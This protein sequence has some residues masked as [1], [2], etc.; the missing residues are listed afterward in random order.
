MPFGPVTQTPYDPGN[1][2]DRRYV[3]TSTNTSSKVVNGQPAFVV[4]K[5]V[6]VDPTT[7]ERQVSLQSQTLAAARGKPAATASP[8]PSMVD[9]FAGQRIISAETSYFLN[10]RYSLKQRAAA[11]L[12]GQPVGNLGRTPV[13]DRPTRRTDVMHKVQQQLI[14]ARLLYQ[15]AEQTLP[16]AFVDGRTRWEKWWRKPLYAAPDQIDARSHLERW[17]RRPPDMVPNP[18]VA[19]AE[20][21][22]QALIDHFADQF[23]ASQINHVRTVLPRNRW[24]PGSRPLMMPFVEV[25]A[26]NTPNQPNMVTDRAAF[27]TFRAQQAPKACARHMTSPVAPPRWQIPWRQQWLAWATGQGQAAK[28]LLL[29]LYRR[30]PVLFSPIA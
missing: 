13:L 22:Q 10:P 27:N 14:P 11:R 29:D 23:P 18:P 30:N 26:S 3:E 19:R 24:V 2:Q 4:E 9:E 20:Q 16:F 12:M 17:L 15:D 21:R 1:P 28:D 5:T 25:K 6:L 8:A 7:G